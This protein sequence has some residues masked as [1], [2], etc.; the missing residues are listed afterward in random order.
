MKYPSDIDLMTQITPDYE[1]YDKMKDILDK[2]DKTDN[3]YFIEGKVEM[4]NGDKMKWYSKNGFTKKMVRE[5]NKISFV[6]LDF[7]IMLNGIFTELSIIYSVDS[8]KESDEDIVKNI[9]L[10][11]EDYKS[12]GQYYKAM[13]RLFSIIKLEGTDPTKKILTDM[14]KVLFNSDAGKLYKITSILKAIILYR[15]YYKDEKAEKNA[16]YVY[17]NLGYK[18]DIKNINSHIDENEEIYNKKAYDYYKENSLEGFGGVVTYKDKFNKKYNFPKDTS[19]SIEDISKITGYKLD[20]LKTIFDK[21]VG[22]Y[23]TNPQ[24]IRPNVTSPE[25]WAMA[26]VYASINPTSKASKIDASHLIK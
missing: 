2:A 3:M 9:R 20:G 23:K 17:R 16:E 8:D 1:I 4:K 26:R 22:A 11:Y 13:K 12:T 10:D 15:G 14:T 6:K 5:I 19:H 24:S 7:V 18:D 21:G 25:Q